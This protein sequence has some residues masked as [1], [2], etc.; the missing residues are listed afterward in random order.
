MCWDTRTP[1]ITYPEPGN[2]MTGSGYFL[3]QQEHSEVYKSPRTREAQT[4]V[5]ADPKGLT[6]APGSIESSRFCDSPP[7]RRTRGFSPPCPCV[8]ALSALWKSGSNAS[9]SCR[10]VPVLIRLGV[11]K[12]CRGRPEVSRPDWRD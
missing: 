8:H 9:S 1:S 3:R 2:G 11:S 6:F 4:P 5:Q 7:S 12:K 10:N